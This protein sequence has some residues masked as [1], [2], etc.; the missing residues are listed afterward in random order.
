MD[1]IEEMGLVDGTRNSGEAE[2][3]G[4]L[5]NSPEGVAR[6]FADAWNRGDALAIAA[7]FVEDA[8]FVNV[9]G[10]WWRNRRRIREAHAYGARCS[11]SCPH[12]ASK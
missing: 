7:L 8:D 5:A 11:Y 6:G 9:V 12:P 1:R 2:R 4:R 3:P 10:L